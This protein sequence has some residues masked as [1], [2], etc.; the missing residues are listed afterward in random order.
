MFGGLEAGGNKFVCAVGTGP[1][2]LSEPITIPTTTPQETIGQALEFFGRRDELTAMGIGSFGPVDLDRAS[3][4]YG[5]ITSTPKLEWVNTNLVGSFELELGL[6]VAF[7]TD[8]N[9]A[10]L[11]EG[12][13]GAGRELADFIYITVGTGIGG[14][15]MVDGRLVHGL[16]HPEMGHIRIPHDLAAD[17]FD[18]AC[19]YHGD[20]LEGLASGPAI[21]RRWGKPGEDIDGDHEAWEL[22]AEYLAHGVANLVSTLSPRRVIMGGGVMRQ[23]QLFPPIRRRVQELLNGYIDSPAILEEIDDFIVEPALGERSGVLG[24]IALAQDVAESREAAGA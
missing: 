18:G 14:G 16:V 17:P 2:N 13:W 21:E 5:F 7:D 1:A 9:A 22:E 8:V 15:A 4:T 12:R 11:G 20:C 10:A 24:A 6:P 3:F 23:R 19:P